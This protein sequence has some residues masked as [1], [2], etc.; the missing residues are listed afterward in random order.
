MSFNS[1]VLEKMESTNLARE[2]IERALS[3]FKKSHKKQIEQF[4]RAL[5]SLK[6]LQTHFVLQESTNTQGVILNAQSPLSAQEKTLILESAKILKPWRKGPFFIEDLKIDSEWQSFIKFNLLAPFLDLQDKEVLDIGC[7]NGYYL[8]EMLKFKPKSLCGFDPSALFLMQFEFINFFAKS[9]ISYYPLGIEYVRDFCTAFGK[10]FDCAFLL[11]V[12]YHRSDPIASL[13][14]LSFCLKSGGEAYVDSLIIE[15]DEE[16]CLCPKHSYAKMSNVYF[17]PSIPALQ[18]WCER[19][20]FRD[21]EILSIKQTTTQEQ[22]KS[23]W[24][25]GMSLDAFLRAD[26]NAT[27]EGYAPPIRGYFRVKKK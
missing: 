15:S 6:S 14:N 20:G 18:G 17:I 23:E 22:R 4:S 13:K 16:I 24:I 12:L 19:A 1:G 7:N 26:E 2:N 27:I 8:F 5:D 3:A 25:D 10:K 9:A 21:F 11:G